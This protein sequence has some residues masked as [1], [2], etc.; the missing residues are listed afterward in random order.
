MN[1]ADQMD[2]T[3]WIA[4]AEVF[5]AFADLEDRQVEGHGDWNGLSVHIEPGRRRADQ[6]DLGA[7][8]GRLRPAQGL[9]RLFCP[10]RL[11]LRHGGSH[12]NP[13]PGHHNDCGCSAAGA[14]PRRSLFVVPPGG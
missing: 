1:P 3:G 12:R 13:Q 7:W 10:V 11:L 9:A 2:E 4:Y 5:H 14:Y 8:C 6:G